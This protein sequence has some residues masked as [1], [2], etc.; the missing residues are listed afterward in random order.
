MNRNSSFAGKLTDSTDKI[1]YQAE[2]RALDAQLQEAAKDESLAVLAG[3]VAHDFNNLLVGILG[4]AD[5]ALTDLPATSPARGSLAD[6]EEA[7]RRAAD[8]CQQ[9][10]AYSGRGR[11]VIQP[12]DLSDLV[13]ET[14]HLLE[15]AISRR[16]DL[17]LHLAEGLPAIE[18]DATQIRQV[19]MNLATNA[20]EA[21]DAGEGVITVATGTVECRRAVLDAMRLGDGLPEGDYVYLEVTDTGSGIDEATLARVFDPFFT[22]KFTGRGLGL[23]AVQGIARGHGG[24]IEVH[25]ESG[26]GTTFRVLFPAT[27][28]V[29][30]A[31]A[32]QAGSPLAGRGSGL[33]L[34]VDDEEIVRRVGGR[35]LRLSGFDVLTAAD[36]REAIEV[37]GQRRDE[38]ACVVLDLS[39]PHMGGEETLEHLRRIRSDVPVIISSGFTEQEVVDRFVGKGIAGFV[40]KPY[41]AAAMVAELRQAMG[42]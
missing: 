36:G 13:G 19:A 6:I 33:V 39:M 29:V 14:T 38:I 41:N 27:D 25:T 11:F 3:G 10:L 20:A 16:A 37:F 2:R 31:S 32:R 7:S 22:T 23:A 42:I 1:D 9:M 28:A 34:L 21:L 17:R 30:A 12:L 40:Q 15:A 18:A 35:M 24:A 26:R 5:L 4:S 8:L